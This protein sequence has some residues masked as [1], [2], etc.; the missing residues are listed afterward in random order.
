LKIY[1]TAKFKR[2]RKKLRSLRERE[3]LKQAIAAL[4]ANPQAG[5]PL[6]GEFKDLWRY[7]Y[8]VSGQERRLIYQPETDSLYLLSFGPREGIYK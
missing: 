6:K 2:L 1:E 4:A 7:A 8:A 5:K 3:A